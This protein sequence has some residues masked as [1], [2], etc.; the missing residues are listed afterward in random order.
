MN[1]IGNDTDADFPLTSFRFIEGSRQDGLGDAMTPYARLAGVVSYP[2]G[3]GSLAEGANPR[4]TSNLV[5]AQEFDIPSVF[6]LTGG[7]SDL[8]WQWGQ[9]SAVVD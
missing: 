2:D 7:L 1:I 4:N 6:G 8:V 3:I 9:V 5:V